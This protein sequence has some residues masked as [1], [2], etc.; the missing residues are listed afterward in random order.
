M[1]N[2]MYIT[3]GANVKQTFARLVCLELN[4]EHN[5]QLVL[6]IYI[7]ITLLCCCQIAQMTSLPP[8]G[9]RNRTTY[10]K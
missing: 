3:R 7:M 2:L 9:N 6:A 5:L 1:V 4:S 8:L 10:Y